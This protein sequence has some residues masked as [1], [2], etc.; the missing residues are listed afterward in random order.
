[1]LD[2][3]E[4]VRLVPSSTVLVIRHYWVICV[5][6]HLV[7]VV[8]WLLVAILGVGIVWVAAFVEE[9]A[10]EASLCIVVLHHVVWCSRTRIPVKVC[11][12][13]LLLFPIPAFLVLSPQRFQL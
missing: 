9:V 1:M 11:S 10:Q 13:L 12:K 7:V 6:D 2:G 8:N 3:C 5:S 4:R